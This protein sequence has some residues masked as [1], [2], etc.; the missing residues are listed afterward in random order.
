MRRVLGPDAVEFYT[1]HASGDPVRA[2][3]DDVVFACAVWR[4]RTRPDAL[5]MAAAQL[6]ELVRIDVRTKPTS[7]RRAGTRSI[8]LQ[9]VQ[10]PHRGLRK[11]RRGARILLAHFQGEF[12]LPALRTLS[13]SR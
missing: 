11:D 13:G 1:R 4:K 6:I 7:M 3:D 2:L 5:Q 9:W 8:L 10:P 12:H